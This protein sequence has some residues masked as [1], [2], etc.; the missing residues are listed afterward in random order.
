[1]ARATFHGQRGEIRKRYREGQED[2]LGALGLVV[3]TMVLWNTI[4]M[5]QALEYI[6]GEGDSASDEDVGRLSPLEHG[7][8]N[9]L[10]TYSFRLTDEVRDG[11]LRPLRSPEEIEDM[12]A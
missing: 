12:V 5:H 1:M 4:Y 11:Q 9:F 10:G 3:N 8:F 2:Q 7:H 6:R